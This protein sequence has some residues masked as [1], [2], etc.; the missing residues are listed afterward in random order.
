MVCGRMQGSLIEESWLILGKLSFIDQGGAL[1][2]ATK[3][4]AG[5]LGVRIPVKTRVFFSYPK[6]PGRPAPPSSPAVPM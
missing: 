4:R 2:V 3:L 5:R 6:L 1:D